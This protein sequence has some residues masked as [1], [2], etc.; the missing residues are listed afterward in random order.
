MAAPPENSV[1]T[2][3]FELIWS[4]PTGNLDCVQLLRY[5]KQP[6]VYDPNNIVKSLLDSSQTFIW[7]YKNAKGELLPPKTLGDIYSQRR[8][9][10]MPEALLV[11]LDGD[12]SLEELSRIWNE[13]KSLSHNQLFVLE[14]P[15]QPGQVAAK[16]TYKEILNTSEI[17]MLASSTGNESF[18]R[19]NSRVFDL[20]EVDERPYVIAL[21]TLGVGDD[22][23][24]DRIALVFGF[25]PRLTPTLACVLKTKVFSTARNGVRVHFRSRA[26]RGDDAEEVRHGTAWPVF[27][28]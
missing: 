18:D 4:N 1:L 25:K 12:G 16:Q 20:L 7:Q 21:D 28:A 22:V 11:D 5:L 2:D 26:M 24:T 14:T 17:Q 23:E 8:P 27:S 6:T 3:K 13:S 10:G 19:R 9:G 15:G